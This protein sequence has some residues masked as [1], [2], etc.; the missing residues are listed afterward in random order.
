MA[1]VGHT[2][3]RCP[4]PAV[5]KEDGWGAPETNGGGDWNTGAET[6]GGGDWYAGAETTGGADWNAGGDAGHNASAWSTGAE[7]TGNGGW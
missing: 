3:T 7:A 5:V 2:K 6:T 1:E 4:N